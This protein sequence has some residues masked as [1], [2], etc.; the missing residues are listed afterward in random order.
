MH[1]GPFHKDQQYSFLSSRKTPQSDH[2]TKKHSMGPSLRKKC[3]NKILESWTSYTTPTRPPGFHPPK[4]CR[5]V[6][7]FSST[8]CRFATGPKD[9]FLPW[10][11]RFFSFTSFWPLVFTQLGSPIIFQ[12]LDLISFGTKG[13]GPAWSELLLSDPGLG[14]SMVLFCKWVLDTIELFFWRSWVPSFYSFYFGPNPSSV[15]QPGI[16]EC[17]LYVMCCQLYVSHDF[18]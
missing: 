6:T 10:V 1:L 17:I 16:F 2:Q 18:Q 14:G 8:T 15:H 12:K 4:T 9:W 11:P 7:S 5:E 13:M 3:D